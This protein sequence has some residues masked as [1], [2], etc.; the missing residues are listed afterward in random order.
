MSS[1]LVWKRDASGVEH[2]SQ[3]ALLAFIREQCAAHEKSRID[4][5]LLT[6]CDS[7]TR[8][9]TDLKQSSNALNHLKLMSHYLYYP[10]LQSNQVWSHIQRGEPL[11]SVLTGKRKQKLQARSRL[12]GRQHAHRSGRTG[13]RVFRLSFPV[14]FGLLLIFTTVAIVLAYTIAGFVR[15]PIPLPW[16]PGNYIYQQQNQPGSIAGHQVTMTP[17]VTA[18]VV[19]TMTPSASTTVETGPTLTPTD[20][21]AKG[22]KVTICTP[23]AY[24]GPFI[25]ICGSGFKTGDRISLILDLY[26]ISTPVTVDTVSPADKHGKF[27]GWYAYSCMNPP[28][29][30]YARDDTLMP[31][32]VVSNTLVH[33]P[34]VGCHGPGPTP[35]STFTPGR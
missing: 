26:G 32:T 3:A 23:S 18:T 13:L 8:L 9:H 17:G 21:A 6:G 2:P 7:C 27:F 14:A 25:F 11:T 31:T 22:P 15:L 30:I 5:H 16:Q 20:P 34:I 24:F 1:D 12:A 10:E 28:L 19:P 33:I 29:S 4:E 35:T